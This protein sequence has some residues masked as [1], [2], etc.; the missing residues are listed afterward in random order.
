MQFIDFSDFLRPGKQILF[1]SSFPRLSIDNGNPLVGMLYNVVVCVPHFHK[2][3]G[4]HCDC[5]LHCSSTN[6]K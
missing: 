6:G 2:A 4:G 1:S 3:Q 5:Y